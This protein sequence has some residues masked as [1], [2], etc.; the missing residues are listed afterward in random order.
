MISKMNLRNWR[1]WRLIVSA[2]LL[3][4]VSISAISVDRLKLH[5]TWLADPAREGR[6]AGSPGA[7]AAADYIAQQLKDMGCEVQMQDFGARRKNV[8]GK[9]GTADRYILIGAHYDGQGPGM[10]SASDNAT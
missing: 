3:A 7:A 8:V 5:V 4:L 1:N 10:P 9:I 2:L 6:F